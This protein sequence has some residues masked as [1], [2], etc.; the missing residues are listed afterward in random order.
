VQFSAT[1]QM[2]A[3]ALQTVAADEN[4]S[5]G[6]LGFVPLHVSAT[7]QIPADARQTLPERIVHTPFAEAPA[8]TEQTWQLP[9]QGELQHLP[10]THEPLEH[11]ASRSQTLPWPSCATQSRGFWAA[12]Q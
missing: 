3:E 6:Q 8:A 2:P 7:S 4:P 12:S 5:A 11:M 9:A 1:S 10:S